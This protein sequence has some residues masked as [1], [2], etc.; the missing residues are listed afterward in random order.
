MKRRDFFGR[1]LALLPL[2][3][4]L[5]TSRPQEPTWFGM[6]KSEIEAI[7]PIDCGNAGSLLVVGP[8]WEALEEPQKP[9]Y[10]KVVSP[11]PGGTTPGTLMIHDGTQWREA[12]PPGPAWEDLEE[13]HTTPPSSKALSDQEVSAPQTAHTDELPENRNTC[14]A[15]ESPSGHP[16][17]GTGAT[18]LD[19]EQPSPRPWEVRQAQRQE[20]LGQHEPSH[21]LE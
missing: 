6:T 5:R 9:S 19:D 3:Q 11:E 17:L 21:S 16:N 2:P 4:Y 7:K 12:H 14:E 13:P 18:C 10:Y 1:L 20:G 8:A 15:H